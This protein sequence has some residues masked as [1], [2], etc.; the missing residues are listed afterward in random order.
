[1][2][3][4]YLL[5]SGQQPTADEAL[6]YY[7]YKRTHDDKGEKNICWIFTCNYPFITLRL[8]TVYDPYLKLI[9]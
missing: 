2:V 3:C 6:K 7:G 9:H 5:Y 8:L 4:C 1:M